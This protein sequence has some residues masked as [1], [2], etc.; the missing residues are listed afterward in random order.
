MGKQQQ[1]YL[2]RLPRQ[3]LPE[4]RSLK[5]R[6]FGKNGCTLATDVELKI[7][8]EALKKFV[9]FS[10]E[11]L[12]EFCKSQVQDR[13][14]TIVGSIDSPGAKFVKELYVKRGD[15]QQVFKNFV[16]S[17]ASVFGIVGSAGVG[18]TSAMCSLALQS[19]DHDFVFFY[20]AAI[21]NRSPLEH[22]AQDLNG[23]FS[24][25]SES[26]PDLKKNLMN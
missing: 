7:R 21:I 24:A 22:I 17:D 1:R 15:L 18:K 12:L 20:N 2:I 23:V 10:D 25:K 6:I 4:R 16:D 9:S 3:S 8:Y 26:D 5:F 19:L 13:M 14:G 11:N